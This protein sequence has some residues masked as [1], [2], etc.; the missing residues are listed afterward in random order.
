MV[1]TKMKYHTVKSSLGKTQLKVL[2]YLAKNPNSLIEP[3]ATNL[4]ND[5]KSV[6]NA[7][8]S[9]CEKGYVTKGEKV[10]T[11]MGATYEGYR[12]TPLGVAHLFAYSRNDNAVKKATTNYEDVLTP[13]MKNIYFRIEKELNDW[14]IMRKVL[15]LFGHSYIL[16]GEVTLDNA[17]K[18]GVLS[19]GLFSQEE[20]RKLSRITNR[21]EP[22]R[23]TLLTAKEQIN[24][25][26][27]GK[28]EPEE[29]NDS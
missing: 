7:F 18:A 20:I 10:K 5:Y 28:F 4:D 24:E 9:L 6:R 19:K 8:L 1:K 29:S 13:G 2:E 22:L 23:N 15:F 14:A 21:I 27:A 3:T 25:I 11:T 26:L 16:Y 12:L 17:V